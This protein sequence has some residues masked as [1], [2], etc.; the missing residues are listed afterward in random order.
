MNLHVIIPELATTDPG[1]IGRCK[2]AVV[3]QWSQLF[4]IEPMVESGSSFPEI[5]N[6]AIATI[7]TG[8]V[9]FLFPWVILKDKALE[10]IQL[11]EDSANPTELITFS[12]ERICWNQSD[13]VILEN[14]TMPLGDFAW[15]LHKHP[16][17]VRYTAIWNKILS[18]DK[19]HSLGISFDGECQENYE[20]SFLLDYLM[21]CKRI[22]TS[23]QKIATFFTQPQPDI[24]TENRINEKIKL[25]N[26]Y[27]RILMASLEQTTAVQVIDK[28]R[29][30]YY[31]YEKLRLN[32]ISGGEK[33]TAK[34]LLRELK[35]QAA[36]RSIFSELKLQAKVC[37]GWLGIIKNYWLVER[38]KIALNNKENKQKERELFWQ[39]NYY[40]V[41]NP[42][43]FFHKT[44]SK[45][46]NVLLYC[47]SSTM[48]SHIEDYYSCVKDIKGVNF[49]IYYLKGWCSDTPEGV[50]LVKSHFIALNKPWD[51]VVCADARVPLYYSRKEAG[52]IYINHGL[53]MISY[54]EG[55]NLY[56][57]TE[58]K[59]LFSAMLEPN[60]S[61][62]DIMS[63]QL[64][65]EHICHTGYK[66]AEAII[67]QS[68]NREQYRKQFGFNENTKVVAVFGTW[69]A[70]SLFHKVGNA[71]ITQAEEMMKDNYKFILSIHPKEY[72]KYDQTVEPLGDY[73]ESLAERGF[74]VRNPKEP[75][76]NYMIAADVVV[77]DYST[78]CEEAMLAG[79]PVV[80]SDFP[81]HRVWKNSII[82][83][84]QR[85]GVIFYK[86]SNLKE[87]IERSITDE[88]LRN[89]SKELVNDLLPPQQ[90]YKAS[91]C[92][93]T[94]KVLNGDYR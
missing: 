18:L 19:I 33:A 21:G 83:N 17:D 73:I 2:K 76:I 12:A 53:H 92:E 93:V 67:N 78:L 5:F 66:N 44:F 3:N 68:A 71:L 31:V 11:S 28:E 7:K 61:Y 82:A 22:V 72:S 75:S 49:Y 37:K 35:S 25:L 85:K 79:K 48:K 42:I 69:G 9:L 56:A 41:R 30:D 38:P 54:D 27:E 16:G 80:L 29:L 89:Y 52:L 36:Q 65:G 10:N 26:Q 90:G 50:K 1:D 24:D 84:Y 64:S 45:E 13:D 86:D 59:G 57:Y 23:Q 62:A 74:I 77:C 32:E 88:A 20:Y 60:K 94:Q 47:E 46:K 40:K 63:T 8:Y 87:L 70:D 6:N 51:L 39:E 43:R 14:K 81:I 58:G 55:E 15:E 34:K 91:V 4:K